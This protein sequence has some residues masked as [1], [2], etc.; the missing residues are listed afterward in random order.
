MAAALILFSDSS[1]EQQDD[2]SGVM[3]RCQRGTG[4]NLST[5]VCFDCLNRSGNLWGDKSQQWDSRSFM[6]NFIRLESSIV[7]SL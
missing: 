4:S 1:K 2:G 5:T 3:S 7:S 6:Y